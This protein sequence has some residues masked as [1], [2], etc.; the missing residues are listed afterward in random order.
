MLHSLSLQ[1]LQTHSESL[2]VT[3]LMF[4]LANS[5]CLVAAETS[6][7]YYYARRVFSVHASVA[8]VM[9]KQHM[10]PIFH[11]VL[12]PHQFGQ[13]VHG[14]TQNIAPSP[15]PYYLQSPDNVNGL[16]TNRTTPRCLAFRGK[17]NYSLR[18]SHKKKTWNI[19]STGTPRVRDSP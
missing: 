14:H 5:L 10:S 16:Q 17:V 15:I 6:S 9:T 13:T 8:D 2:H 3:G 4:R 18:V 7:A 12:F 11:G 19:P 1:A